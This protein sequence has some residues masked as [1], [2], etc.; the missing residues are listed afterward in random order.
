MK[1]SLMAGIRKWLEDRETDR[2]VRHFGGIQRCPW[3]RQWAQKDGNKNWEFKTCEDDMQFDTLT[4]GVC[5]GTSDWLWAMGFIYIKPR[6]PPLPLL[7]S[8]RFHSDSDEED[9]FA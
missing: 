3:C 1:A 7:S 6:T 9:L 4:C 2:L 8:A 5:G